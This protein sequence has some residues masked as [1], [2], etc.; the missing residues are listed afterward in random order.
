MN[1]SIIWDKEV[2]I[3]ELEIYFTIKSRLVKMI[4]KKTGEFKSWTITEKC[5]IDEERTNK[6]NLELLDLYRKDISYCEVENGNLHSLCESCIFDYTEDGSFF[7][8]T[9]DEKS[10]ALIKKTN[11]YDKENPFSD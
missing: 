9:E 8:L 4:S 5:V 3:P 11:N 10:R 1:S 7:C 2:E 6:T